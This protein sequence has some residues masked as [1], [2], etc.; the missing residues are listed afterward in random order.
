MRNIPPALVAHLRGETL[1][2]ALCWIIE[3]R[4]GTFIRGTDHDEDIELPTNGSPDDGF[5]GVYYAGSNITGSNTKTSSDGSVG[6]MEVE[7]AIPD[8]ERSMDVS[9]YDIEAGL[10]NRAPV[11]VLI[12]NWQS[13]EDGR[14]ELQHGYLGQISR[15]SDG[16]Y[17]TEIRGLNQLLAQNFVR[18][19]GERCQ[20]ARFGDTECGFNLLEATAVGTVTSVISR[21]RFDSTLSAGSPTQINPLGYYSGGELTFVSGNNAGFMREVKRDD[22]DSVSGHFGMWDTFP[23]EIQIGDQFTVSPGCDRLPETCKMHGRFLTG[24]RGYGLF[25]I[26]LD[27]LM[28]GPT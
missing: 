11:T 7:G 9:V 20:V 18:T 8:D 23:D 15:D 19:F 17:R 27:A 5:S 21:R 26:G 6:N 1:T 13:P 2:T 14:Y 24:W 22:Y 10:L 12:T 4:D 16:R 28:K 3:K 25:I